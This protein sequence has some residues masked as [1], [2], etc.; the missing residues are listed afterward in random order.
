MSH[1]FDESTAPDSRAADHPNDC[2]DQHAV[3]Y[4][5]QST[6]PVSS[7]TEPG[8]EIISVECSHVVID[9][10]PHEN[11]ADETLIIRL[12]WRS[13][14]VTRACSLVCLFGFGSADRG[15]KA[16][17]PLSDPSAGIDQ[18]AAGGCKAVSVTMRR[19]AFFILPRLRAI[20]A[21][22]R[23]RLNGRTRLEL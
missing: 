3:T 19:D 14:T 11:S 10:A 7:I 23:E 5:F 2:D 4:Q 18:A 1:V 17:T 16:F 13:C 8:L 12:Y 9:S 20:A 15:F 21:N 22:R 6:Y